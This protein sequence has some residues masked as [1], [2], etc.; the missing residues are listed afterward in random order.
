MTKERRLDLDELLDAG[1]KVFVKNGSLKAGLYLVIEMKDNTGRS[2]ALKVPPTEFPICVSAQYSKDSIR[3]STDLRESIRKGVLVLVDQ[4]EAKKLLSTNE[5]KEQFAAFSMSPYADNAPKNAVRDSMEKV[6]DKTLPVVQ[7]NELLNEAGGNEAIQHKV[8][9]IIVSFQSKEKSSK[10]TL[11]ALKRIKPT[12]SEA[13]LHYVISECKTE[14]TIREFAESA[15][16]E[17]SA[18][19]EQPFAS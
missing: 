11:L 17:L 7:A 10:D 6:K 2:K 5:A 16:A 12:M 14:T 3:E 13:D 15:L 1:E 8:K 18:S 19:P 4:E 9:G